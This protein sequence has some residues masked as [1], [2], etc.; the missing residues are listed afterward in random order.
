MKRSILLA[1]VIA[2]SVLVV[3]CKE[4]GNAPAEK[5]ELALTS[6]IQKVSYG[7]GLNVGQNLQ[8]Q[9]IELDA[10][11]FT[12]GLDDALKKAEPRLKQEEIMKAMQDFQQQQMAKRKA[13]RDASAEKNKTEA[14]AFFAENGKKE[15]VVTTA[16]GLQYKVI[17]EG[18]GPKPTADDTVEVNY[19]GTFLNGEEFDSS[20]KRGKPVTFAVKGVVPGWT[21]V[22]QLMPVGS[23]WEVALP[24]DLAY[25]PGGTGRIG[26][27]AALKFTIEL[28]GI[29]EKPKAEAPAAAPKP[30]K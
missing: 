5:K 2:S 20:Y 24:S 3:A 15:G 6:E 10:Q 26:P 19:A 21:E 13:E 16:S 12:T 27:N 30:K 22:L 9:G 17:T 4:G 25:G 7:L 23:K 11:A 8:A 18:K 28:L 29:K 14:A 1:G